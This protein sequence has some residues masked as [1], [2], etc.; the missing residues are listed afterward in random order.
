V[1]KRLYRLPKQNQQNR[2]A[3]QKRL[4]TLRA[5]YRSAGQYQGG[6]R[7]IEH[8]VVGTIAGAIDI[9]CVEQ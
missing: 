3:S 5:S 4:P 6:S 8:G 1:D 7:R 2:W 9:A